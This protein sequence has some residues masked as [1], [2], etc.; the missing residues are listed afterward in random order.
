MKIKILL[1]ALT[2]VLL[3]SCSD[4]LQEQTMGVKTTANFYTTNDDL[5]KAVNACYA[6]MNQLYR[7]HESGSLFRLLEIRLPYMTFGDLST[8]R[9]TQESLSKFIYTPTDGMINTTWRRIYQ[10]IEACNVFI[11]KVEGK[12]A[13]FTD[14]MQTR[15]LGEAYF[16]RGMYKY[17]LVRNFG[18]A[19][20]PLK[21]TAGVNDVYLAK[22]SIDDMYTSL[23][24]DFR[25][26]CGEENPVIKLSVTNAAADGGRIIL[27][28]GFC[29]LADAYLT[30]KDWTNAAKYAQKVIDEPK[31]GLETKIE[32]LYLFEY[33]YKTKE[34]LYEISFNN[35]IDPGQRLHHSSC[36]YLKFSGTGKKVHGTESYVAKP[37]VISWYE[38]GDLRKAW[39]FPTSF[40][41]GDDIIDGTTTTLN[42][43]SPLNKVNPTLKYYF[44][45]KWR[46]TGQAE[47]PWSWDASNTSVYKYSDALLIKA[48][49]LNEISGPTP[50]AYSAINLLRKRN[51]GVTD[52]SKDLAGLS[53]DDFRLTIYKERKLEY[54][55]E[56]KGWYDL[57][58]T[59]PDLSTVGIPEVKRYMPIPQSEIDINKLLTQNV[60]E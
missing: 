5:E 11:E 33:K 1:I 44:I 60:W 29:A 46:T 12:K 17:T 47:A 28:G 8:E 50:D 26:A 53:K 43:I 42:K 31:Y 52:N 37:V 36:P 57:I 23:I 14:A 59:T 54:F 19:P 34:I 16:M 2:T 41:Y 48:E 55:F 20:L 35:H 32:S 51:F 7:D 38:A 27:G 15:T 13:N 10:G 30:R 18:S 4:F 56:G 58:R 24:K 40:L 25:T 45:C 22:S 39:T 9:S 49:A 3:Y 21:A 6:D